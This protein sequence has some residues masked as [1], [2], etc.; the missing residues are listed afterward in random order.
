MAIIRLSGAD[1]L[2]LREVA[3]RLGVSHQAPYKHFASRDHLLAEVIRRC[4]QQFAKVLRHSGTGATTPLEGMRRIGEAYLRHAAENPVEYRLMFST[5]WPDAAEAPGLI[6][7]AR[8][9]FA[10]LRERL[11][12]LYPERD[13]ERIDRDAL[14]VWSAIHGLATVQESDAMRHLAFSPEK[15]RDAVLHAMQ[16]IEI[17]VDDRD[18]SIAHQPLS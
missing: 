5:P 3:R 9:A 14:F 4:F 15:Q 13:F 18:G 1:G 6:E 17:G 2:S 7:D 11:K 12:L 16:M 8:A 10:V